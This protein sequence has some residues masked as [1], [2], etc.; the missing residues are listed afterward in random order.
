L[1]S[2]TKT[3]IRK[4]IG[5]KEVVFIFLGGM[6]EKIIDLHVHSKY[7]RACSKNLELPNIAKACEVK[8]IDIV[9]TGDFTHPLWFKHLEEHLEEEN[10]GIYTLKNNSSKTRFILG[11]EISCIYKHKEK[12]RRL[13][14]LVFAPSIEVARKFNTALEQKGV[15]LKSDG[16]PIMGLS[17]KEILQL[18]LEIDERMMVIPAH[19]WTPWFSVFGSK[20]GYDSLTECFEELIPHIRAIE[21][22]LSSDPPMN[23]RLS[24]LDAITLISNSDAH[25]LENLGREAN[26]CGFENENEITYDEIKRILDEGDRKK[27][28]YT[29][30]FYP[31]EGK[32]HVDGHAAC[33]VALD[34]AQTKR[35]GGLCPRCKKPLTIGVLHRVED[36]ADRGKVT[37]IHE[38]PLQAVTSLSFIP[39]KHIVPLREIIAQVFEVG[40][41]S[42]KVK[43]EY[44]RLIKTIGNEFYILLHATEEE[45][46]K[47][48]TD[49][50]IM[51]AIQ[52]M[53]TNNVSATPGYDGV[54][55]VIDV[56]GGEKFL[57][58][59]QA[60]LW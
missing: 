20:S 43:A 52:N 49:H 13:H 23:H 22:G 4:I 30:E 33:G 12:T 15:N 31:E 37:A 27:F 19:A 55:G 26:V 21:T 16:R 28:L 51:L 58:P 48:S 24:K 8:G 42:K 41:A 32:Y 10:R 14:V 18:C 59:T 7:S 44:D 39:Y 35:E 47:N 45:I 53:R 29:I 40:V 1:D 2:S 5:N 50:H 54:F 25:G 46:K 56:L 60:N 36:L 9:S 38:L 11:T 6:V 57:K 34:P 17:A 3:E